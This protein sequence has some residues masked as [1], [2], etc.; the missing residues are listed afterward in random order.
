[1]A[2]NASYTLMAEISISSLDVLPEL[3]PHVTV[4]LASPPE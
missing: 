1:M 4:Y 3:Q 2:L